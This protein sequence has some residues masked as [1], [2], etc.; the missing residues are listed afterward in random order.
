MANEDLLKP[1]NHRILAVKIT[2]QNFNK[3]LEIEDGDS[4][5]SEGSKD[6]FIGDWLISDDSGYQILPG[7][8]LLTPIN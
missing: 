3:L 6:E 1:H 5:L 4:V 7:Y 8:V 2:N